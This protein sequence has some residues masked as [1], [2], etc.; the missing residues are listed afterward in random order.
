MVCCRCGKADTWLRSS[1]VWRNDYP[2]IFVDAWNFVD[3]R[4]LAHDDI[5]PQSGT[6]NLPFADDA[7]D[8]LPTNDDASHLPTNDDANH[9]PTDNDDNHGPRRRRRRR[10]LTLTEQA[11]QRINEIA[12]TLRSG[13]TQMC[14]DSPSSRG[15]PRSSGSSPTITTATKNA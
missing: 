7:T 11:E 6:H 3:G 10:F 4:E 2:G 13:T 1:H 14:G 15:G 9:F 12:L 8:H 5:A